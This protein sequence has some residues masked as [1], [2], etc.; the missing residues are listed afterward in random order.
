[1]PPKTVTTFY[2]ALNSPVSSK[3]FSLLSEAGRA[4]KT[5]VLLVTCLLCNGHFGLTAGGHIVTVSMT[6]WDM[7]QRKSNATID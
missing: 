5:R 7:V 1:M 4:M 6:G 3:K 2:S